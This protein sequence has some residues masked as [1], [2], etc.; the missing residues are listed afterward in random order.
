MAPEGAARRVCFGHRSGCG[1]PAARL[2]EVR[3]GLVDGG[4]ICPSAFRLVGG[5]TVQGGL[6]LAEAILLALVQLLAASIYIRIY[7]L[8]GKEKHKVPGLV[9]G[10]LS[11]LLVVGI[12][13]A[14]AVVG[15][16][17]AVLRQKMT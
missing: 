16:Y 12:C 10:L 11:G 3:D 7:L 8:L 5:R 1:R 17:R 6:W 2:C 4:L 9:G 15:S 13:G 14:I